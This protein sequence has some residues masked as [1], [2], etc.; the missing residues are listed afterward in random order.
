ME[1]RM[2][3]SFFCN[4]RR[5]PQNLRAAINGF[6]LTGGVNVGWKQKMLC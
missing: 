2:G 1:R 5:R 6:K 3:R 4:V